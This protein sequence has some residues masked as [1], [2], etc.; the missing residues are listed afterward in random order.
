MRPLAIW[1]MQHALVNCHDF[2]NLPAAVF[3][4]ERQGANGAAVDQPR[5]V[6]DPR[7]AS[8]TAMQHDASINQTINGHNNSVAANVV[9]DSLT[10]KENVEEKDLTAYWQQQNAN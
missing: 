8:V 9:H 1:A 6:D 3:P 5:N 7:I 2:P 10:S 4:G